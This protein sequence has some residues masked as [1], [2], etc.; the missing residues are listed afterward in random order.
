ML[1]ARSVALIVDPLAASRNSLTVALRELGIESIEGCTHLQEARRRLE[2]KHYDIVLC[3]QRFQ[4]EAITGND[5]LDDLRQN[6]LLPLSTLFIIVSAEATH[7]SVT[8]AAES[9]LDG[10]LLKPYTVASLAARVRHAQKRKKTLMDISSAMARGDLATAAQHCIRRVARQDLFWMYAARVGTELLLRMNQNDKALQLLQAVAGFKSVPWVH[11]AMARV[12]LQTGRSRMAVEGLRHLLEA[13]PEQADAM[14]ILARALAEQGEFDAA[15]E[16]YACAKALTPGSTPRLQ[17]H[18]LWAFY[19]G[20]Y[21]QAMSSLEQSLSVGAQ[22]R[23]FDPQALT[24]QALMHWRSR[25]GLA[26]KQCIDRLEQR[27][28]ASPKD[29]RLQVL[30]AIARNAGLLLAGQ[31]SLQEAELQRLRHLSVS[32][33]FTMDLACLTL[34]LLASLQSAIPKAIDL[35][36]WVLSL[37]K[38]FCVSN[39]SCDLLISCATGDPALQNTIRDAQ[40][41]IMAQAEGAIKH[42]VAG[43]PELTAAALIEGGRETRNAKLIELANSVLATHADRIGNLVSLQADASL[44]KQNYGQFPP[45]PV[46]ACDAG[47][48]PGSLAL[49][50]PA[51]AR[52]PSLALA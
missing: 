31:T 4:G 28:L 33:N 1:P 21:D 34:A 42:T 32:S 23:M 13:E 11:L 45:V 36:A 50:T 26:L 24:A 12:H 51:L 3:E 40:A 8:E 49:R 43:N 22:S 44:L 14:D 52:Q 47:R 46:L 48:T 17:R 10:Y 37:A 29:Q 15:L 41:D 9:A 30:L 39:S 38:R 2:Q 35:N 27:L 20:H 25:D 7:D 5:L 19:L 6:G 16:T 18:G